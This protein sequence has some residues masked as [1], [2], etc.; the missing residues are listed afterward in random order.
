[1][2]MKKLAIFLFPILLTGCDKPRRC[3]DAYEA[4]WDDKNPTS[5]WS[6]KEEIESYEQGLYDSDMYD[7]GYDDGL[8]RRNP[9]YPNDYFYMDGYKIGKNY[10]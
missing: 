5:D 3:D 2:D 6:S 1:M 10:R 8:N 4:A 9:K 7:D